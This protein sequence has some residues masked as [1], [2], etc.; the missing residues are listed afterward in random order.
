MAVSALSIFGETMRAVVFSGI[1][2]NMT[3]QDVPV[4]TILNHTDVIVKITTAAI[5]GSDLHYYHGVL[6]GGEVPFTVGH[7]GVGYIAEIGE[8]VN[9]FEVG[10]YVVIPDSISHSGLEMGPPTDANPGA[11]GGIGGLQGL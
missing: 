7:E 10:D 9:R 3:V 11:G 2:Y 8:A 5:C 4:P 6:G 1:P